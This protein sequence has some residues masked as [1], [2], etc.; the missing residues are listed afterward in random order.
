MIKIPKSIETAQEQLASLDGLIT[1]KQWDRAAIVWAFTYEGTNRF[2]S[3]TELDRYSVTAFAGRGIKG[4]ASKTSVIAYRKA[5]RDAME[6]IGVP[7][8]KPG[9][10][11][12]TP[13]LTFP[14]VSLEDPRYRK[15][16]NREA[17]EA[18]A[19]EDGTSTSKALDIAKNKPAMAAAIKASPEVAKAAEEA[20]TTRAAANLEKSYPI[21]RKAKPAEGALFW[22]VVAR[23]QRI[24]KAGEA[25][26]ADLQSVPVQEWTDE[27]R[28]LLATYARRDRT[29]LDFIEALITGGNI[30]DESLRE[31]LAEEDS[32]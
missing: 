18:Q 29:I 19:Q 24:G 22:G 2:D 3:G 9:E 7:D 26:I 28:E 30:T 6:M 5:W 10:T 14:P 31:L 15:V 17:I 27:T 16:A 23:L 20:L 8:V 25:V 21:V 13:A 12:E 32:R 11:V 1:A 4:L